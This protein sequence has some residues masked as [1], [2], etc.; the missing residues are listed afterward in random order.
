MLTD[1]GAYKCLYPIPHQQGVVMYE[2]RRLN[3]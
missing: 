1:M 2:E 3:C